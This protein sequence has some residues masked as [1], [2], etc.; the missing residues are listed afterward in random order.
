MTFKITVLVWINSEQ[1]YEEAGMM[2][3]EGK[4]AALKFARGQMN[5]MTRVIIEPLETL[6]LP[7]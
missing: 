6:N 3:C 7:T 1:K 5:R 4:N 2:T